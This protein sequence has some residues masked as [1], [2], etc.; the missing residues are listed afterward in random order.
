MSGIP[1]ASLDLPAQSRERK[2]GLC[3]AGLALYYS[4]AAPFAFRAVEWGGW[5]QIVAGLS[6]RSDVLFTSGA[7]ILVNVLLAVFSWRATQL[8]KGASRALIV[9]SGVVTLWMAGTIGIAILH[10]LVNFS[11]PTG[12]FT[13]GLG[14][15]RL[16]GYIACWIGLWTTVQSVARVRG[17]ATE[18]APESRG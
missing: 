9:L 13:I 11:A 6:T 12:F 1:I 3:Y 18:N 15:L 17:K 5:D 2:V 10:A 7:Y 4:A 8:R 14:G 16:V